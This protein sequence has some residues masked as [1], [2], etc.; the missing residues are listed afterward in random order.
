[1]T[2]TVQSSCFVLD[3]NSVRDILQ[4]VSG[5]ERA[6]FFVSWHPVY[7]QVS[8]TIAWFSRMMRFDN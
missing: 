4:P 1:M 2:I 7:V 6:S 8:S 5:M 3:S